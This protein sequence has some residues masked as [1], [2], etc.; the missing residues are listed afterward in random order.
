MKV[1]IIGKAGHAEKHVRNIIN[2]TDCILDKVL[3][4]KEFEEGNS[5]LTNNLGDLLTSD[6]IILS[7]PTPTHLEYLEDLKDF[8][9]YLL[10]EKPA[11]SQE[12]VEKLLFWPA[13]RKARVRVNFTLPY[14]GIY[15]EMRDIVETKKLGNPVM[16]KFHTSHGLAQKESFKDSWRGGEY[17]LETV[18][19]HYLNLAARL[20]GGTAHDDSMGLI[21]TTTTGCLITDI[22]DIPIMISHSYN[23]PFLVD[24]KLI[25]TEGYWTYDGSHSLIYAPTKTF[26]DGGR[27]IH[28]PIQKITTWAWNDVWAE[29]LVNAWKDFKSVVQAKSFFSPQEFDRDVKSV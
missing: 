21:T 25:C 23:A 27:F 8:P 15:R 3:T 22:N 4:H 16:L 28:P 10:V 6:V 20:L 9:G 29:G 17:V 2:D 26:D 1:S 24:L 13:E 7:S 14:T 11:V 5:H 19:C 18:G 12:D